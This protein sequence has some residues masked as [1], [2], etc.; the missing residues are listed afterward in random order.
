MD[1]GFHE[2][3]TKHHEVMP[4]CCWKCLVMGQFL[5]LTIPIRTDYCADGALVHQKELIENWQ[6]TG[7]VFNKPIFKVSIC[8]TMIKIVS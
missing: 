5:I 4:K 7:Y 2:E 1:G 3:K 6:L 8:I